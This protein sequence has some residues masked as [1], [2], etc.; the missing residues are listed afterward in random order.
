MGRRSMTSLG[1]DGFSGPKR[2]FIHS[3][4]SG[5]ERGDLPQ[6]PRHFRLAH[7]GRPLVSNRMEVDM[8]SAGSHLVVESGSEYYV[9]PAVYCF[10][11]A[12][13]GQRRHALRR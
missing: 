13:V 4:L 8:T 7:P 11:A 1:D 2:A 12:D 6:L 3:S 5:E 10:H 9:T